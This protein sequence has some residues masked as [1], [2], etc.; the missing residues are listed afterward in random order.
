MNTRPRFHAENILRLNTL[1]ERRAYLDNNVGP[2]FR[3]WVMTYVKEW[4]ADREAI[5]AS[6]DERR[7]SIS[8][9]NKTA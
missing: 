2:E 7:N 9:R 4:W 3:Q 6:I 1:G 5:L 8:G